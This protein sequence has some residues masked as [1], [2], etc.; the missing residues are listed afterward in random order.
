MTVEANN[1]PE[2]SSGTTATRSVAENTRSGQ[3]VGAPVTATDRDADRLTYS[4]GGP[5]ADSFTIDSRTGQIRTSSALNYEERDSYSVTVK[6]DDGTGTRNSFAALS[7]T[8]MV[9]N[10]DEPPS[11]PAAPSVS[12]VSGSSTSVRVSW[13][14]PA[15]IW[16]AHYR[17]RP[18]V[19]RRKQLGA[20]NRGPTSA[21]T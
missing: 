2:F 21:W 9:N 18:A 10:M 11:K 13:E 8:I 14:E 3:N 6:A 12:G 15:N 20:S 4:L 1:R 5:G 7:V 19:P 17:L 16:A